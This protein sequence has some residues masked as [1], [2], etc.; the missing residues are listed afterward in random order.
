[1]QDSKQ[2]SSQVSQQIPVLFSREQIAERVAA[3]GE[4]ISKDYAGQDLLLVTVLKGAFVF[5]ADLLRCIHGVNV[6]VDFMAVSSY[7]DK[8]QTSGVVRIIKDLTA[9]VKDK[10][11]LL[12]EDILDSG[13]TLR[14]LLKYIGARCPT[15]ITVATLLLKKDKQL[16]KIDAKYVGFDC[17]D[18]FIVGYGLDLAEQYRNLP[19]IG[20]IQPEQDN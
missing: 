14:Y 11:V 17:P 10:H 19:Y 15:S 20:I 4:Q 6:E 8:T 5:M 1:M 13:V 7:G 18:R 16:A 2:N 9:P 12:V 3:L